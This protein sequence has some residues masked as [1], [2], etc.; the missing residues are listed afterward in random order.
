MKHELREIVDTLNEWAAEGPCQYITADGD[1]EGD[2]GDW[3]DACRPECPLQRLRR[4]AKA[5]EALD[6]G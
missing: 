4:M 6:G 2:C 5:A 1:P 3:G